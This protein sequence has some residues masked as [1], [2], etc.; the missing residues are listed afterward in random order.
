MKSIFAFVLA[1][2]AISAS[3]N[4]C[5]IKFDER[6]PWADVSVEEVRVE[7]QRLAAL[8]GYYLSD[9]ANKE[10]SIVMDTH[11]FALPWSIS[12]YTN[13]TEPYDPKSLPNIDWAVYESF[14]YVASSS[15]TL[16]D[17]T[18]KTRIF[19]ALKKLFKKIPSCN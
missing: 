19:K 5:A 8:K 12:A 1:L 6:M 16:T 18:D 15:G 11:M 7:T 2:A 17:R 3:A 14:H 10:I 13:G 9:E 4:D